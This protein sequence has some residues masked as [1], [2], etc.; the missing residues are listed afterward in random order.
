MPACAGTTNRRTLR[1]PSL[2]HAAR[3][4]IAAAFVAAIPFAGCHAARVVAPN[5]PLR[6]ASAALYA[7]D[8]EFAE[9]LTRA[10]AEDPSHYVV[11]PAATPT[12]RAMIASATLVDTLYGR[13][14]QLLVP[15]WF[16]DD[17]KDH[18]DVVVESHGV[19][20]LSGGT[21]GDRSVAFRTGLEYEPTMR[22]LLDGRCTG[23]HDAAHPNGNYRTDRYADLLGDGI[24]PPANL[25]PGDPNCLL[26][27]RC[28]PR[29]SMFILAGLNYL[30]FE[31]IRNWVVTYTAR[32]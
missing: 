31:M 32:P 24:A 30:D 23:C 8:I 9:P 19:Q 1:T 20:S 22:N 7:I 10:S 16:G 26:V 25:I 5:P 2:R 11:Y 28:K 21:T 29:N 17:T 13:V 27:R 12:A 4:W 14:V 15:D 6:A 18:L 3:W